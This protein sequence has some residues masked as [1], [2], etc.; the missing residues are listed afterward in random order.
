MVEIKQSKVYQDGKRHETVSQVSFTPDGSSRAVL[1]IKSDNVYFSM[2][3]DLMEAAKDE[4]PELVLH[5]AL[6]IGL[7]F[8]WRRDSGCE[9]ICEEERANLPLSLEDLDA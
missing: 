4:P 2:L 6:S 7:E 5:R 9:C 1:V 3:A 8:L